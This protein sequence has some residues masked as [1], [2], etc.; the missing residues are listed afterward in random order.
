MPPAASL[1]VPF[2]P[3]CGLLSGC[4]VLLFTQLPKAQFSLEDDWKNSLWSHFK[5]ISLR[6][7]TGVIRIQ[8]SRK[9]FPIVPF[10]LDALVFLTHI[11]QTRDLRV[12]KLIT[13]S[14]FV[15]SV[16]VVLVHDQVLLGY[17]SIALIVTFVLVDFA[18]KQAEKCLILLP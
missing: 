3:F 8:A 9:D 15:L 2:L 13:L 10:L 14:K 16:A 5:Y 11:F 18:R 6:A 7:V 4:A 12:N 1:L 17:F